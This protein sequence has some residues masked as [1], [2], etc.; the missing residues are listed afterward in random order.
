MEASS[1][2]VQVKGSPGYFHD[3]G[4][5]VLLKKG[6]K[7]SWG[8]GERLGQCVHFYF[9]RL[10]FSKLFYLPREREGGREMRF[11]LMMMLDRFS[12]EI[13]MEGFWFFGFFVLS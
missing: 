8:W 6:N 2:Q 9:L 11:R 10:D 4:S 3:C 12:I 1:V 13:D 7:R 5:A